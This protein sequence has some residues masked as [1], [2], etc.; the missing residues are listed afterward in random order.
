MCK[1]NQNYN[2]IKEPVN[3]RESLS[4]DIDFIEWLN[5]GTIADLNCTLKAFENSNMYEDC[6]LILNVINEKIN[7]IVTRID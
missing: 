5:T 4:N 2:F 1:L 3:I 6:V 7:Q